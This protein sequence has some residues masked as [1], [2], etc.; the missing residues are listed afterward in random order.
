[1]NEP[2]DHA[3]EHQRLD[4]LGIE[5][6]VKPGDEPSDFRARGR[7]ASDHRRLVDRLFEIFA[8]HV[9]I[10]QRQLP[11]HHHRRLA[12]GVEVDELV[13]LQPGRFADQL[14]A[15]ALLAEHQPDLA[16]KGA[17]RELEEV[18]HDHP[19]LDG[20]ASTGKG[21]STGMLRSSPDSRGRNGMLTPRTAPR[22]VRALR[23]CRA[24]FHRG[25]S[26]RRRRVFR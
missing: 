6:L 18:P 13:A 9:R 17:E 2:L 11:L 22:P 20:T 3:L 23:R 7:V 1:M 25:G 19:C 15:H 21:A 12:G 24:A 10:A 26:G 16:G 8:D 4:D 14:I 5:L